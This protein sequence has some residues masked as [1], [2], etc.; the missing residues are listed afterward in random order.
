[1]SKGNRVCYLC[2]KPCFG[3]TCIDCFKKGKY[4]SRSRVSSRRKHYIK[5]EQ[6]QHPITGD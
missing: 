2:G 1:M 4:K 5:R 6:I 3:H